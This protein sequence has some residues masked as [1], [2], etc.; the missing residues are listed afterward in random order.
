MSYWSNNTLVK[1][2]GRDLII[3]KWLR[4]S[5]LLA[6]PYSDEIRMW[7]FL[8][9]SFLCCVWKKPSWRCILY[10]DIPPEWLY[11]NLCAMLHPPV[12][13]FWRCY[14]CSWAVWI[15]C[16][17]CILQAELCVFV[18]YEI[19]IDFSLPLK[20]RKHNKKKS[21]WS[22]LLSLS[23]SKNCFFLLYIP[24]VSLQENQETQQVLTFGVIKFLL[25]WVF[26]KY[27]DCKSSTAFIRLVIV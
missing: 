9:N 6:W 10:T 2:C 21:I 7:T 12:C 27:K 3:N 18:M 16:C 5:L 20:T 19:S 23:W 13:V 17:H 1:T 14:L 8:M 11:I 4:S 24:F 26:I 22:I 15:H 25:F